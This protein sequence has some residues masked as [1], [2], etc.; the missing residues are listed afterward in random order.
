MVEKCCI[1]LNIHSL[2]HIKQIFIQHY[3]SIHLFASSCS[4]ADKIQT[5]RYDGCLK[6]KLGVFYY[7]YYLLTF[8]LSQRWYE[9]IVNFPVSE[10]FQPQN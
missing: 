3:E 2:N 5:G 1:S 10:I 6:K 9:A 7:Y 4:S 8:S